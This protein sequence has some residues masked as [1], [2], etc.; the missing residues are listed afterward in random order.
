MKTVVRLMG[1]REMLERMRN[2]RQEQLNRYNMASGVMDDLR[3]KLEEIKNLEREGI[4][5]RLDEPGAESASA[6]QPPSAQ[7][8]DQPSP[9]SG[10]QPTSSQ[11]GA[12]SPGEDGLS[13][14]QKK[15]MLEMIAKRKQDY[16]DCPAQ[17]YSWSDQRSLRV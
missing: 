16:L 8:Q 17:R 11:D 7:P 15:R 9:N 6:N 2:R 5:H 1:L 4:Q 14:E 13:P 10:D 12:T 3:Q